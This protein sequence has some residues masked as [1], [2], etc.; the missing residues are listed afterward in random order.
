MADWY[1]FT[2]Q[3]LD[4]KKKQKELA[5]KSDISNLVKNT[6]LNKKEATLATKSELKAGQNKII[7]LQAFYLS[8]C[9]HKSDFEGDCTQNYFVF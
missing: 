3:T 2:S 9:L 7:N 5:S 1:T 4:T 6:D 8:Y